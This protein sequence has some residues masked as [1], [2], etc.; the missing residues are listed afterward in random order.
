MRKIL[1]SGAA[2]LVFGVN[3]A[4]AADLGGMPV[5]APMLSPVL[6][7][8]WTGFYVGA[9]LGGIGGEFTNNVPLVSGP[10]GDGG[11]VMG[12]VQAGYNWQINQLVFGIEADISA[13]EVRAVTGPTSFDE[14]WLTTVRG[15]VGYA[16]QRAL[17]YVTAGVGFT[18][19]D[20][21][22]FAG[23]TDRW[24][25]GLA[26]GA[27]VEMALWWPGLSGRI[28]YLYVDVPKDSYFIGLSRVDG[29]SDNHI[30]RIAVNYKFW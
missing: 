3:A 21:T 25:A 24:Q 17:F 8:N 7:H 22:N 4:A 27:G 15:R 29:G 18:H 11:S 2:A 16:W 5:K 14:D 30:G 28:E 23:S 1:L 10:V 12:G 13:I 20:V 26:V 19:V 9:H 6:V